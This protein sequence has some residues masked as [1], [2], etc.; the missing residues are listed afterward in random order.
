MVLDVGLAKCLYA[1]AVRL[2]Y[3]SAVGEALSLRI[4]APVYLSQ[5]L[6]GTFACNR[7]AEAREVA[8][9]GTMLVAVEAIFQSPAYRAVRRLAQFETAD[10]LV[11]DVIAGWAGLQRQNVSGG[12][13]YAA[14]GCLQSWF[15][16]GVTLESHNTLGLG[17]M[18]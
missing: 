14:H 8:E 13:Q 7:Q 17:E 16:V 1:V 2:F 5:L 12:Q 15:P 6:V 11:T 4:D 18:E 10:F 3:F 9:L